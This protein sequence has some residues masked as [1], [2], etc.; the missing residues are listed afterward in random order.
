LMQY[1]KGDKA[2]AKAKAIIKS[3]GYELS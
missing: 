1:I 3:I 2:K